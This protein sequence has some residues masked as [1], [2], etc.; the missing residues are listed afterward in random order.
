MRLSNS[1]KLLLTIFL[2]NFLTLIPKSGANA[3]SLLASNVTLSH[4]PHHNAKADETDKDAA[5][6][7]RDEQAV[8]VN[9][10]PTINFFYAIRRDYTDALRYSGSKNNLKA[11][12]RHHLIQALIYHSDL[13]HGARMTLKPFKIIIIPVWQPK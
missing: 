8:A 12:P 7:K 10:R 6:Y 3:Q 4:Y 5:T 9:T 1:Q 11:Y 2:I 13:M